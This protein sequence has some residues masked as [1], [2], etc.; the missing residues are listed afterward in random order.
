MALWGGTVRGHPLLDTTVFV[1]RLYVL[2]CKVMF[3][4]KLPLD[5]DLGLVCLAFSSPVVKVR[6]GGGFTQPQSC[7]STSCVEN[8][9]EVAFLSSMIV[10]LA[11]YA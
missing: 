10:V 4:V 1:Q 8:N 2:S 6:I 11:V 7:F 5:A 3:K 9:F